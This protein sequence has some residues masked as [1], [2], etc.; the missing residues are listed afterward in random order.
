[1][2]TVRFPNGVSLTYNGARRMAMSCGRHVLADEKGLVIAYVPEDCVIEHVQPCVIAQEAGSPESFL[3][4]VIE[5]A[6]KM[7][8]RCAYLLMDLK[9]LLA[10]FDARNG[11][12]RR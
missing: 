11:T 10:K 3:K 6:R 4:Y 12:W 9:R 5:H 7:P 1:M 8:F 2:M